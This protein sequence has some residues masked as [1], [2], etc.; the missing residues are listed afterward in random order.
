MLGALLAADA[1]GGATFRDRAPHDEIIYFLL[2]DRFANADPSNDRGGLAGG[3]LVTGFDPTS[4]GFYHGGDLAG[5]SSRLD[6]IRSLGATAIWLAPVF[7][8]KPV[9]GAP[10]E[11]SAGYHGYWVTDFTRVDPHFG[12]EREMRAFVD[13]AHARGMKVY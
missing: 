4:K 10:G 5:L 12:N 3:R 6:Y 2:P 9:Q 11:E 7:K 13:A 1:A 8:N